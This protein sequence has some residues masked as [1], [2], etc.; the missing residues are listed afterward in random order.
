MFIGDWGAAAPCWVSPPS[1]LWGLGH[2]LA[3]PKGW[4][5]PGCCK[6]PLNTHGGPQG[7]D[8]RTER[9]EPGMGLAAGAPVRSGDGD[10]GPRSVMLRGEGRASPIFSPCLQ[11]PITGSKTAALL[12]HPLLIAPLL[13]SPPLTAPT[14]APH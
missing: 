8:P 3:Y 5:S 12:T 13:M 4:G 14:P 7:M 1:H 6:I 11:Y 9:A 10:T 2:P